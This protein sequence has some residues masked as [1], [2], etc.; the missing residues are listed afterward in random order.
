MLLW[1][2]ERPPR[3]V[4]EPR[5]D[6]G[7]HVELLAGVGWQVRT[8]DE[9]MPG[10]GERAEELQQGKAEQTKQSKGKFSQF[11][12]VCPGLS[13]SPPVSAGAYFIIIQQCVTNKV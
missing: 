1:L 13:V 5:C 9:V 10:G 2:G 7:E 11:H 4:D 12:R 3:R 6:D 8:G